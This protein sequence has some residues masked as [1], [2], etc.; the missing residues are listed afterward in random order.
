MAYVQSLNDG[1]PDHGDSFPRALIS[2]GHGEPTGASR[3]LDEQAVS[4]ADLA[5]EGNPLPNAERSRIGEES[6]PVAR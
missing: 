3:I 2:P 6:H 5:H 1:A 4:R